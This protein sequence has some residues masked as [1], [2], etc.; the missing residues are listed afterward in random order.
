MLLTFSIVGD[1][2]ISVKG[3]PEIERDGRQSLHIRH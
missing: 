3:H 1:R 2:L